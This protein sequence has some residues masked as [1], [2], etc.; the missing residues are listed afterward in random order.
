MEW[1]VLILGLSTA[2]FAYLWWS[3]Y[4]GWAETLELCKDWERVSRSATD[5]AKEFKQH[6]EQQRANAEFWRDL[7]MQKTKLLSETLELVEDQQT[8]GPGRTGHAERDL[9]A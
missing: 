5:A 1:W 7:Y 3:S 6:A 2:V 9:E 8:M 4:S